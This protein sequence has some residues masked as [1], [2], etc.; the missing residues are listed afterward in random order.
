MPPIFTKQFQLRN[1]DTDAFGRLT[2]SCLLSLLQEAAGDHS[3]LLGTGREE[4]ALRNLFW[5][6]LRHRVQISRLPQAG[7]TVTVETWPMPTTRTAYPRSTVAYDV[8][9][10]ELFRGI[11]L[12]VLMDTDQRAMVLPGKSGV[13]VTGLIRGNEL[14]APGSLAPKTM[15]SATARQVQYSDLDC[16]G[17]MNNCRYLDWAIDTLPSA[18]HRHHSVKEFSVRYLS[19]VLEGEKLS[20]SWELDSQKCLH[21]EACRQEVDSHRPHTHVFSVQMQF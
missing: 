19:E 20:L 3:A 15:S 1:T 10:K 6:V 7:E 21:V 12:W 11:S 16:N 5:A 4:L 9:G 14:T 13:E 8:N 17:H 18:F 2:P